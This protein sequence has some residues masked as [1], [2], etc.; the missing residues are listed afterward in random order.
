MSNMFLFSLQEG[1]QC[2]NACIDVD[3][4]GFSWVG[5][6]EEVGSEVSST[7][8]EQGIEDHNEHIPFFFI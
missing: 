3:Y 6:S 5:E 8:R 2:S 7:R 1:G 4:G